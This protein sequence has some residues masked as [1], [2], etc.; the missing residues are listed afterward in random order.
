LHEALT[1]ERTGMV[2]SLDSVHQR[3]APKGAIGNV[4]VATWPHGNRIVLISE[5]TRP[6]ALASERQYEVAVAIKLLH[7]EVVSTDIGVAI[8]GTGGLIIERYSRQWSELARVRTS[9]PEREKKLAGS[10][11]DL[12]PTIAPIGDVDVSAC[13][14]DSYAMRILAF[15]RGRSQKAKAVIGRCTRRIKQTQ[16]DHSGED[17]QDRTSP[18]TRPRFHIKDRPAAHTFP[19]LLAPIFKPNVRTKKELY[20]NDAG[21]VKK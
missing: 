6:G 12:H 9:T 7:P 4:Y 5:L 10:V 16:R 21:R 13:L 20:R 15:P 14:V 8:R 1:Q 2:E 18:S 17:S 11:K 19:S 3:R